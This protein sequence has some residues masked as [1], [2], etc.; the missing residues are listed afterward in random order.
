MSQSS[1]IALNLKQNSLEFKLDP[2]ENQPLL[3]KYKFVSKVLDP[4]NDNLEDLRTVTVRC[5]FTGCK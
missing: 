1:S 3:F 5:L 4:P 2:I